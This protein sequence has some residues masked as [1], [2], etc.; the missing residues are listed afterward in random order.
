MELEESVSDSGA[1]WKELLRLLCLGGGGHLYAV[2]IVLHT[3]ILRSCGRDVSSSDKLSSSL[4][5]HTTAP[6][7]HYINGYEM[8]GS[9]C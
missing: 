8:D 7:L 2:S 4:L 9:M 1:N 5:T 3:V 6:P